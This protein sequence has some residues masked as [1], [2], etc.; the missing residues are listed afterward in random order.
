MIAPS[1]ARRWTRVSTLIVFAAA[2]L[3][4]AGDNPPLAPP[5]AVESAAP[6]AT[7]TPP[8]TSRKTVV[9]DGQTFE[10]ASSSALKNVETD[11]YVLA[12]E[13]LAEWTQ[14]VTVQRLTLGKP[15]TADEFVAY[16]QKR[17]ESEA[18]ATLEILKQ[19]K[20]ASVFVVRFPKSERNDE[21]VML[22][23]AFGDPDKSA[24]LNIIQYAIKPTRASVTLA[25]MRIKSWRNKLVH[26]AEAMSASATSVGSPPSAAAE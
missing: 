22:C 13:K 1:L 8:A 14:L 18:G 3:A 4:Y 10:L 24:V 16:F 19:A 12:G 11:E 26:Q 20:P 2:T 5:P 25:E 7:E 9:H 21:Q 17:L 15:T 23:L 6:V